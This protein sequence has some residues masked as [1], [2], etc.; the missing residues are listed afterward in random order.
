MNKLETLQP[1]IAIR[2]EEI[3]GYQVNI[4]NFKLAI[5]KIEKDYADNPAMVEF[6]A[7]LEQLLQEN[8]TEQLKAIIIRDVIAE[9]VAELEAS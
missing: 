4:D 7:R 5:R 2:D 9:Q 3:F 6:K 8:Q 1:Q